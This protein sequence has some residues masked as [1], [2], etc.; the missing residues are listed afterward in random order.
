MN[1]YETTRHHNLLESVF[2][3][4]RPVKS[5]PEFSSKLEVLKRLEGKWR[6]RNLP[7]A[8]CPPLVRARQ[9]ERCC[10]GMWAVA[11]RALAT[12][13]GCYALEQWY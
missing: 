13:S 3:S 10:T 12:S 5:S 7:E 6:L 2:C 4:V 1:F 11:G 9:R 8:F